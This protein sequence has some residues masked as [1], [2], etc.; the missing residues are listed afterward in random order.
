ML[1]NE[2]GHVQDGGN[3]ACV[4]AAGFFIHSELHKARPDVNAA[5]HAHSPNG[6]A[7]S[8]FGKPLEMITQ[9]V[10]YFYNRHSLYDNFGGIVLAA[11]EGRRI[12]RALGGTNHSVILRNHGLL[13][14]GKTVDEAAFLFHMM[15]R[16]CGVQLLV[17]QCNGLEKNY[18]P[19]S[20][21][22]CVR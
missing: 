4:N 13:T 8:V 2:D 11:E 19:V 20:Q 9:D 17:N 16:C 22:T 5:C 7:Y 1:V 3:Q 15:E 6:V 21:F 14:T 18:I 12:A 10:C